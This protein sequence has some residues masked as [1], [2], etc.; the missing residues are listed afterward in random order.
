LDPL[1]LIIVLAVVGLL[2]VLGVRLRVKSHT[3]L[4]L[5]IIAVLLLALIFLG[6]IITNLIGTVLFL[7]LLLIVFVFRRK[8]ADKLQAEGASKN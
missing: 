4:L 3:I 5:I 7:G 2:L 1:E 8:F 6:I